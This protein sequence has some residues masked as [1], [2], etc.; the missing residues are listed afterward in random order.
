MKYKTEKDK[1]SI[2][3]L[4]AYGENYLTVN[5]EK[6]VMK[7]FFNTFDITNSG[8]LNKE[9]IYKLCDYLSKPMTKEESES[10]NSELLKNR[11]DF[12]EFFIWWNKHSKIYDSSKILSIISNNFNIPYQHQQ[13]I[14]EESGEIYTENYRIKHFFKNLETNEIKQ[15]SPW[16][17]IP[18]YVKDYILTTEKTERNKYNFICE[19]PKWTRAK[20]EIS[21]NEVYNPIKQDIKNGLPRFYKHGDMMWNYGAFPQTWESTEHLFLDKYK[22]DSDPVDVIEI[23]MKQMKSGEVCHIKVLGILGMIDEG[24]MDWKVIGI[25][26]SDPISQ[27]LNDINDVSKQLPGCLEAIR[28]WLRTYKMCQGGV[29]NKFAFDGEY[30]N[31]KYAMKIIDG[32]HRM[33]AQLKKIDQ[34]E[35]IN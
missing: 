1:K 32:S 14:I 19:I 27:F 20:F 7:R 17:N 2:L 25:S 18:L 35:K 22:G 13:L 11:V 4:I 12:E 24:E 30:Q 23:G 6:K 31:K 29:E 15:I 16:H 33:W 28:E 21:T 34:K 26:H 3:D 10:L 8:Y 5:L 9:E